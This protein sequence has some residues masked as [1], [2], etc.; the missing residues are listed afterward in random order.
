MSWRVAGGASRN[1]AYYGVMVEKGT[2][3]RANKTWRKKTLATPK[4]TGTMP[5]QPFLGPA[6]D[7]KRDAAGRKIKNE[8]SDMIRKKVKRNG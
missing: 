8:L 3:P 4:S 5:A 7:A 2:K 6:W 1:A